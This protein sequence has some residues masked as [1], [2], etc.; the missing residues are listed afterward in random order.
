M[1]SVTFCHVRC[2]TQP[3]GG[4]IH[5]SC[6]EQRD[7]PASTFCSV[8]KLFAVSSQIKCQLLGREIRPESAE[9]KGAVWFRA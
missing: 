2:L 6:Q 7:R 5:F 4:E 8:T 1:W 9:L 3:T